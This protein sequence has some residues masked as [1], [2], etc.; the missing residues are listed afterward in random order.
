MAGSGKPAV[1]ICLQLSNAPRGLSESPEKTAIHLS[2]MDPE[3][4]VETLS[5]KYI[6]NTYRDKCAQVHRI[7]NNTTNVAS[8]ICVMIKGLVEILFQFSHFQICYILPVNYCILKLKH[9]DHSALII[10]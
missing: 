10:Y 7:K 2:W 5:P 4:L 6:N 9:I 3:D 1:Y 8:V